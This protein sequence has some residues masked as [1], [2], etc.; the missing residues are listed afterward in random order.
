MNEQR[1][2]FD[3]RFKPFRGR[4]QIEPVSYQIRNEDGSPGGWISKVDIWEN[5]ADSST[6]TEMFPTGPKVYT[7]E[8]DANSVAF[9]DGL[10]WL[11]QGRPPLKAIS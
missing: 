7:S 3:E 9:W 5:E 1:Q 6:I 11:E 2:S 10:A 4:F 8:D